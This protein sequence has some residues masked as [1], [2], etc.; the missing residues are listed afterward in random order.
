MTDYVELHARS[1]FSFLEGG[2]IPEEYIDACQKLEMPAMALLDRDGV[3]GIPRFHIAAERSSAVRAHVGSEITCT[4]GV[5]Y[6]L[7]AE[8]QRGYQNLCRMITRMKLRVPKHPK[9]GQIA[10][11]TPEELREFSEGLICLAPGTRAEEAAGIFGRHNV[12]VELQRHGEREEEAWNEVAIEA[13]RRLKLPLVATNGVCY[14]QPEQREILDVFTCL[15]HKTTLENAGRLLSGN[16]E[17][18]LKPAAEMNRLFADLPEAIANTQEIS[19]RLKYEMKDL[20]Y[21]FPPYPVPAEETMDSFLRQRTEEGARLRFKKYTRKHREQIERELELIEKLK[22][23]GLFS[24]RL[25]HR[26]SFAAR[27][28]FWCRGAARRP[29]ARSV[30]RWESRRSIRWAWSSCSSDFF[31][32]SAANGRT[33]ISICPAAISASARFN[34]ST[35][36]TEN[37]ARP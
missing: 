17:R 36:A 11:A 22:L 23:G 24:D 3:Y 16:A 9:P 15:Y 1:A 12:Y 27:R 7:L 19:S 29:I 5:R 26:A 37:W 13:A 30:M 34:T 8:T 20:G 14:A 31:P 4:D 21:K 25:G 33:S 35:S 28:E 10:A 18:Y 32:K 6:P 2:S